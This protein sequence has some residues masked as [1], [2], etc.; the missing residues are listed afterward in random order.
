MPAT[1]GRPARL[2]EVIVDP[3][4]SRVRGA[5]VWGEYLTTWIYDL[6]YTL[7]LGRTGERVAGVLGAL[8]ALSLVSGLCLWMPVV[9]SRGRRAFTLRRHRGSAARSRE[10]HYIAGAYAAMPLLLTA[11]TGVYMEFSAPAHAALGWIAPMTPWPEG[12]RSAA[13]GPGGRMIPVEDAMRIARRTFPEGEVKYALLPDGPRGVYQVNLR[14]P[15]EAYKSLGRTDVWIDAYSAAV[16]ERRDPRAFTA[17][18][19]VDEWI[20]P[21]HTGEGFGTPSRWIV[22]VGGLVP[23]V[24][25]VS[26]IR[27]WLRK[28][29][30]R[31]RRRIRGEGVAGLLRQPA[32]DA[33]PDLARSSR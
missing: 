10:L 11:L 5:R 16:L 21:L 4:T 25:Y 26:G 27:M 33:S 23:L 9:R 1:D 24:L 13:P 15:G 31:H 2:V 30:G 19:R 18:D 3:H 6:H 8:L 20:F 7:R 12:V 22:F 14:Q 28:R 32:A 29:A 17:G